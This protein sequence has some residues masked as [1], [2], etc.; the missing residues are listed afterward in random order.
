MKTHFPL[1]YSLDCEC[2]YRHV[3]SIYSLRSFYGQLTVRLYRDSG[4]DEALMSD[5]SAQI[6]VWPSSINTYHTISTALKS[7]T[8]C[9]WV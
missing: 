3:N 7:I 6:G 5:D 9:L 4:I 1:I 2:S 8:F